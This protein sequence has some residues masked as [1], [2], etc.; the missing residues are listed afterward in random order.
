METMRDEM[1]EVA[2]RAI[3]AED[4]EPH[5]DGRGIDPDDNFWWQQY[6]RHA[7]A[8]LDAILERMKEPSPEM[9]TAADD[10]PIYDGEGHNLR[11]VWIAM[12]ATISPRPR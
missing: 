11:D 2:A 6:E 1:I 9:L 10:L 5:D 4:G 7:T 12:L 3:A 8:A